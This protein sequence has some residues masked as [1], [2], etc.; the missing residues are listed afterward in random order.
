MRPVCRVLTL[1][2]P[3]MLVNLMILS[4]SSAGWVR[5]PRDS[6]III[7]HHI[8]QPGTFDQSKPLPPPAVRERPRPIAP[9]TT[10]I[11]PDPGYRPIW[12]PDSYRWTGFESVRVPGHWVWT[13]PEWPLGQSP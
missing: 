2:A 11:F 4:P 10:G 8:Q 5:G 3:L 1:L 7:H 13:G 6:P 12:V 9:G